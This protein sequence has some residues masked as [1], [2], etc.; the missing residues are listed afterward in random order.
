MI[1]YRLNILSLISVVLTVLSC[2]LVKKPSNFDK[3]YKSSQEK[4]LISLGRN[5]FPRWNIQHKFYKTESMQTN[6]FDWAFS[7]QFD[8]ILQVFNI[9]NP[10]QVFH[11][12]E[13]V[14]LGGGNPHIG[15]AFKQI[16]GIEFIHDI[17]KDGDLEEEKEKFS[18]QS[19][20]RFQR[21][22]EAVK[23]NK[24]IFFI[25]WEFLINKDQVT[26]LVLGHKQIGLTVDLYGGLRARDLKEVSPY[27]EF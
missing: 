11:K 8:Q 22:I 5:C 7:N 10:S 27:S 25:R 12:S 19:L 18:A 23:T 2:V 26:E 1:S 9:K 4:V 14:L 13:I 6:F 3:E 15:G 17:L 24:Q 20:R 16:R 21:L